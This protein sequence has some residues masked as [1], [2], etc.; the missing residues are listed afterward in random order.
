MTSEKKSLAIYGG[1]FSPPHTG[2]VL[3][4]KSYL[5]AVGA[6]KA[7]IIPAKKP[8]HK[9]LDGKVSDRD[10]VE[11]CKLAFSDD[12]ELS[13]VCAVSE[14]E[15]MREDVSYTV[16]TVEH[17]MAEGYNDIYLLIG[18]DMLLTFESW[19]RYREL[20][21]YV[22]LCYMDRDE[23]YT[24]KTQE[25]AER[26]RREYGAKIIRIDAPVFQASSSQIRDRIAQGKSIGGLVP[27]KVKEYIIENS[28]YK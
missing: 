20:M 17:F 11:M 26:F 22:T 10:R 19:Y 25:C 27:E 13:G 14:W 7:V 2:H 6:E 16:N 3:A 12:S 21:S 15:L 23:S 24:S 5:R 28:L 1:S 4:F 18:T 8:P 9:K